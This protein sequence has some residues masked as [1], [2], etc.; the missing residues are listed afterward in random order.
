MFEKWYQTCMVTW[1]RSPNTCVSVID[2]LQT[3]F[4]R[5]TWARTHVYS[6]SMI[7][8]KFRRISAI[9]HD[10]WPQTRV[11]SLSMNHLG[12]NIRCSA[13]IKPKQGTVADNQINSAHDNIE[14]GKSMRRTSY[15]LEGE[16]GGVNSF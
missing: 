9:G 7:F 8:E 6:S 12:R 13:L 5:D 15:S 16:E 2:K 3:H 14:I 1:Y 11:H 10:T 4:S